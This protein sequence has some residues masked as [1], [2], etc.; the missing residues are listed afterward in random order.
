MSKAYFL[1]RQSYERLYHKSDYKVC[2]DNLTIR[3][4]ILNILIKS[5]LYISMIIGFKETKPTTDTD[6]AALKLEEK[7]QKKLIE[8][9]KFSQA[10]YKFLSTSEENCNKLKNYG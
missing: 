7:R 6:G 1:F 3:A 10:M 9:G 5:L 8:E 4:G 2:G